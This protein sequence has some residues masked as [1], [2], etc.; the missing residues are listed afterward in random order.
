MD[1]PEAQLNVTEHLQHTLFE[2]WKH[3]A[4]KYKNENN[5]SI[6]FLKFCDWIMRHAKEGSNPDFDRH[7]PPNSKEVVKV[8]EKNR[9]N[10]GAAYHQNNQRNR[11][12]SSGG[13][14]GANYASGRS[15][16]GGSG[17]G[18]EDD[19]E[20][21]DESGSGRLNTVKT[22]FTRAVSE[23]QEQSLASRTAQGS[24]YGPCTTVKISHPSCQGKYVE[25]ATIIDNQSTC[26]WVYE[27]L[28]D[29]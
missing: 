5:E 27:G 8:P 25:G 13:R 7:T 9:P 2:K 6:P 10:T 12:N 18:D 23:P 19:D 15:H 16:S 29:A 1:Y 26:T 3:Y 20:E 24:T 21:G 28:Y 22:G 4:Y 14:Q 11:P 17:R